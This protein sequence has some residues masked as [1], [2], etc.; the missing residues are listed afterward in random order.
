[1]ARDGRLAAIPVIAGLVLALY[2]ACFGLLQVLGFPADLGLPG[3]VR[4]LG[5]PLVLYGLAMAGWALVF[6]GPWNVL[7][8]TWLTL[9]KLMRRAPVASSA[10]RTEPLVVAGP[11]RLVRHPLYSGV[12]GLAFGIALLVDH[13]WAYLGALGLSLWFAAVLAPFE[14]RELHA[15][16]G[17]AYAEYTRS[18]RRFVPI[19]RGAR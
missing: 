16:F 2:L 12:D 13:P 10:G 3:F 6:R 19:R 8:S 4:A 17:A 18:V 5:I 9:R 15:L 14:E 1:M 7:G 11:Y